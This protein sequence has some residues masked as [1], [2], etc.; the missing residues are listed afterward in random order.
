MRVLVTG[1]AGFIGSHLVRR[2][3]KERAV[4]VT[5]LDNLH[6]GRLENL[7]DCFTQIHFLQADVRE[8][9]TLQEA[10]HGVDLVYHLAAQSSVINATG[11]LNYT[12]NANVGGKFRNGG[13]STGTVFL[14][15]L[16]GDPVEVAAQLAKLK[17][18]LLTASRGSVLSGRA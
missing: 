15:G 3:V 16:Q 13:V 8:T 18:G 14:D 5:V 9:S 4:S 2:L 1:G 7:S 6:R 11:D 10:L 12:F 17:R